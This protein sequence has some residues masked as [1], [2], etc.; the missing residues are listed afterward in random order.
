MS[1]IAKGFG[2]E[3]YVY[4]RTINRE[5]CA[6]DGVSVASSPE[7]IFDICH[8]VSLHIPATANTKGSINYGLLKRLPKN[9][10]LINTARQEVVNEDDLVRIMEECPDITYVSDFAP[11]NESYFK[12]KLS[13][14]YFAPP[15][16]MGAQTEEAN[17][18]AGI[19]AVK[20]IIDYL[21][22]GIETYRVN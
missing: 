19:A 11:K 5:A 3:V 12:E 18:N 4:R 6:R 10:M 15:K 17:I 1:Q 21:D 20:Q 22:N 13:K 2:M 14:R 7:E 8:Y 16:K 9:A